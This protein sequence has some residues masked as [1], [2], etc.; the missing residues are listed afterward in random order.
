MSIALHTKELAIFSIDHFTFGVETNQI[1][2]ILT[3]KLSD[4]PGKT[5]PALPFRVL[6]YR[7]QS[8]PVFDLRR[9]FCLTPLAVEVL[10]QDFP[11][12]LITFYA[13]GLLAACSVTSVEDM[14]TVSSHS[15][16][17]VPAVLTKIA[18]KNHVWGFYEISGNLLPLIDLERIIS[19]QDIDLYTAFLSGLE[20][21][22]G[23][24]RRF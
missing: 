2:E 7:Q 4:F 3:V 5:D 16:K 9:R 22:S 21:E 24:K 11:S 12:S 19:P 23:L 20:A 8:L 17:S 15:L 14:I 6:Q 18:Y 13:A 1:Q 10:Q